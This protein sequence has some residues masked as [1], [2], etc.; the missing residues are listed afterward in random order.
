[1]RHWGHLCTLA[2]KLDEAEGAIRRAIVLEKRKVYA[3]PYLG[4]LYGYLS[5]ILANRGRLAEALGAA[6]EA[7]R[8]DPKDPKKTGRVAKLRARAGKLDPV[9][10]L[11]ERDKTRPLG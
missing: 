8:I 4:D 2:G 9:L 6:G 1:M 5:D 7:V 11:N 3:Q 10:D